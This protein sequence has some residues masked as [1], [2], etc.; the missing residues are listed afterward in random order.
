MPAAR[1][2]ILIVSSELSRARH[3]ARLIGSD[4][5]VR[6]LESVPGATADV[7]RNP[8]DVLVCEYDL[9]PLTGEELLEM[10]RSFFPRVRRILVVG[11]GE[12]AQFQALLSKGTADAIV[13]LQEDAR[14]LLDALKVTKNGRIR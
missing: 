4:H 6:I 11:D 12:T 5:E 2:E 13:P 1:L 8:P 10:V 3:L 9:G 7:K 14:A